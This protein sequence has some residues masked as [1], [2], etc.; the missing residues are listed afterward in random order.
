MDESYKYLP[1]RFKGNLQISLFSFQF[2]S[3]ETRG[4]SILPWVTD[5]K[6]RIWNVSRGLAV[7]A[8]ELLIDLTLYL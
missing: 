1:L 8:L 7:R 6:G 3:N 2:N 5:E 4:S